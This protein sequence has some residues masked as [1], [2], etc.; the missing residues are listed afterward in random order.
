MGRPNKIRTAGM[1][2]AVRE[3]A[4]SGMSYEQIAETITA[5]GTPISHMAVSR[6]IGEETEERKSAAR[7][8]ASKEAKESVPLVT[9]SLRRLVDMNMAAAEVAYTGKGTGDDPKPDVRD[10]AAATTAATTAIRLL[11]AVTVG[12]APPA[13]ADALRDEALAILAAK[14]RRAQ[15]EDAD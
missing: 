4:A 7:S 14:R 5:R 15:G 9:R 10:L 8:V 13:G 2:S 1:E 11:H 6:F 3:L 12:E